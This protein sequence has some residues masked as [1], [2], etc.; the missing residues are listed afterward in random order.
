[1]QWFGNLAGKSPDWYTERM[2][3]PLDQ[4]RQLPVDQQLEIVHKIWDG[5]HESSELV[6]EWHIKEARR[7]AAEIAADPEI[8][9]TEDEVWKRVD[10]MLDD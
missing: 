10:G 1:M 9:I 2:S 3:N 5:L 6:K 4:I 8:A 7:R